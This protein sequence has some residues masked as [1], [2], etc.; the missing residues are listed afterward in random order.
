MFVPGTT[1]TVGAAARR[2]PT[3]TTLVGPAPV[4]TLISS[5]GVR[6]ASSRAPHHAR[7][8]VRASSLR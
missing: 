1:T 8:R 3:V 4:D 6:H 2:A 5:C 7:T